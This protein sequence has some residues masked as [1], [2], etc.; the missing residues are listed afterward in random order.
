MIRVN[1]NGYHR[2]DQSAPCVK[3]AADR[4]DLFD[5]FRLVYDVY[6]SCGLAEPNCFRMRV[7]PYHLLPETQVYVARCRDEVVCTMT[8]VPDKLVEGHSGPAAM[9]SGQFE[10]VRPCAASAGLAEVWP[11]LPMELIYA[12]EI[13]QR[14]ATG[15]RLAEVSCLA[16]RTQGLDSGLGVIIRVMSLMAQSARHRGID[17][18][19]IAVHPKHASFYER[20]IGFERIGEEKTY[21]CVCHKPAVAL[22]LDLNRLHINHP[23]AYKR[24][25][26]TPF[27]PEELALRPLSPELCGQLSLVAE[28][29]CT[30]QPCA[31]SGS[32]TLSERRQV[33]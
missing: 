17:E 4:E 32:C 21:A 19:V 7:T 15:G 16:D 5:A 22:A 10:P 14:R 24:F 20:F 3:V 9:P 23:R 33:A 8:L 26:G 1:D 13:Q 30:S 2:R 29:S 18:L 25:F 28:A 31:Y 6:R 27:P 11:R 12:R